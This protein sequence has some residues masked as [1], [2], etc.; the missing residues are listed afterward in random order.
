MQEAKSLGFKIGLHTAGP[1]AKRLRRLL[2]YLDWVSL[3]IKALP[4]DYPA[5]TGVPGSGE[6]A[7]E[8][9]ELL[10]DTGIPLQVRT[11]VLPGWTHEDD[12][13]PLADRLAAV[14]VAFHSLQ[15]C[16]T[17]S[18]LDPSLALER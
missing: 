6:K 10:L 7:W 15:R 2:P 3:E 12:I 8:S 1:Y 9:L 13:G 17:E 18:M 16:C 5:I 11:T 14:G 4:G